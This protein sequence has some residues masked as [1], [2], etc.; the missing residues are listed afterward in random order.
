MSLVNIYCPVC[1]NYKF[2]TFRKVFDDRYGEPN[3]Y[4]LAKCINC[5]HVSTYPRLKNE[6][7]GKLYKNYYPREKNNYKKV[8]D[9]FKN[10]N[11][12]FRIFTLWFQGLIIKAKYMQKKGERLRYW[13]R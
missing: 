6:D 3:Q 8:L 2:N 4:N 13:L 12:F 10:N 11:N 7:L 9:N 1:Q 5:K